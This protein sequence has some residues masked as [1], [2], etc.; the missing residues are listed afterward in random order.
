MTYN[1]DFCDKETK[2]KYCIQN[3]K[4]CPIYPPSMKNTM[5]EKIKPLNLL[6]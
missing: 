1:C 5:K 3:G 6:I 4:Y 2:E